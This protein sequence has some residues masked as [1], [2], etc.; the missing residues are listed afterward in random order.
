VSAAIIKGD[1]T[2]FASELATSTNPSDGAWTDILAYV[3]TFDLTLTGEDAQTDRMA[4]IFLAA[5]MATM[6]KRGSSNAA[7]PMTSESVGG[8]RRSYGLLAQYASN[9]SLTSTRY[10]QMYLEVLGASLAAGPMVV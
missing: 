10:G 4:K 1:V 3:N 5:H 6:T 9:S 7:G 2:N 8:I